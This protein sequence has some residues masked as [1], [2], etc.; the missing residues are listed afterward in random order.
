MKSKEQLWDICMDIYRDL[1]KQSTPVANFDELIR[2]GIT[3]KS[4]W[5]MDYTISLKKT[6]EI[7]HNHCHKHKLSKYE[8]QQISNEVYLGCAPKFE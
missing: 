2:N 6:E 8:K 4:M 3:K 7:M 5:F 1:Y